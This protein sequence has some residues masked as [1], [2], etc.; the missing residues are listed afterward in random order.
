M[1]ISATTLDHNFVGRE[2]ADGNAAGSGEVRIQFRE[3]C[4]EG[5]QESTDVQPIAGVY[6]N[7]TGVAAQAI[8]KTAL[9]LVINDFGH[10][11]ETE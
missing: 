9:W 2:F 7:G 5:A 3:I 1:R 10:D 11:F 8:E 6:A 4:G